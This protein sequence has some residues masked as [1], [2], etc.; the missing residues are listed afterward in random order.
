MKRT[1]N[2]E[3]VDIQETILQSNQV[4]WHCISYAYNISI[5]V[6]TDSNIAVSVTSDGSPVTEIGTITKGT[7]LTFTATSAD[8][9]TFKWKVDGT[10]ISETLSLNVDTTNWVA[11]ATYTVSLIAADAEG[12]EDSYLAQI[13]VTE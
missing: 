6:G 9:A 11:G 10:V 1:V 3:Y 4:T 7:P 5:D 12:N 13:T 8:Y 2:G